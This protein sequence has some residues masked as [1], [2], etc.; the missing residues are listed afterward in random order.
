MDSSIDTLARPLR[1]IIPPMVTPLLDRDTLDVAGL[2]RLVEHILAGGVHGLFILGTTGE[3]PGLSHRL[4]RELIE[5]V[6]AQVGGRVP[7]LVGITDT[8]FVES[9][10]LSRKAAQAG[11]KGLVLAPPYYFSAGQPELLEY[12]GHLLPEL[13]LPL[14]L[15]NTPNR[16]KPAFDPQT[17][18]AAA[19]MPGIAGLKDSSTNMI[20][21]HHV[22]LIL[23]DRPDFTLL[24]GPE[25]LLADS[26][27]LGAHGGV[28][29]GANLLP[30]LYVDLYAAARA[31]DLARVEPLHRMVMRVCSTIYSVG[32]YESSFLKGLKC[33]L[34]CL[35][36][37]S[38]FVAEPFHRFREPQRQIICRHMEE[39]GIT[40]HG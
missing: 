15:Y 37:C 6:C 38:D 3:T 1:G 5:R 19:D 31:K 40:K 25:Q 18:R 30:R 8:S 14:F 32:Q 13:P 16:P 39:L 35:G 11:A 2:E 24:M 21:F 17:V 34:S 36:I 27:L 23:E 33:A 22:Q 9:V 26:V 10:E 28:C 12:L 29:G 20:Y 7:V 4:R